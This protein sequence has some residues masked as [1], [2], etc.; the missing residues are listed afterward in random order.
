MMRLNLWKQLRRRLR[1]RRPLWTLGFCLAVLLG[2]VFAAARSAE[3]SAPAAGTEAVQAALAGRTDRVEVKLRRIH[4]CGEEIRLLGRL[5]AREASSL[6]RSHPSWSAA[7]DK[8]GVLWAE[9]SVDD[10]PPECRGTAYF[11]LDKQGNL[12]LFDGPP[13]REKVL[14]TFFQM[15]VSHME[16][17]LPR[18]RIE[19]L[20][21][22]IPVT[23]IDELNSVLSSFSDFAA[24][25]STH[26]MTPAH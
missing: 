9:E 12:S 3:A 14:R 16:S 22:G 13:E 21:R 7:L 26:V 19:A 23:G 6:L 8:D 10:W 17:S 2:T 20:A 25:P 24:Q 4:L 1:R 11:G 5:G 15:D 18:D